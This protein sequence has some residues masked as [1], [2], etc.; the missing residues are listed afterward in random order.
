MLMKTDLLIISSVLPM[1]GHFRLFPRPRMG[2]YPALA[3]RATHCAMRQ[4]KREK[5]DKE[6]EQLQF[7]GKTLGD[8]AYIA[9]FLR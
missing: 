6:K 7:D 1:E 8:N 3:P 5:N 2:V 4:K 9:G